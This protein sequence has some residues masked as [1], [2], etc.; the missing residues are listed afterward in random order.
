MGGRVGVL[1]VADLAGDEA[2]VHDHRGL[3]VEA[4]RHGLHE[5]PGPLAL[6]ALAVHL[7]TG[8]HDA[9]TSPKRRLR[10]RNTVHTLTHLPS[11]SPNVVPRCRD[12]HHGGERV[13]AR[14]DLRGEH[15]LEQLLRQG[16]VAH[17]NTPGFV[18]ARMRA[19]TTDPSRDARPRW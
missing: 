9:S 5:L 6:P 10:K 1:L 4:V 3:E 15:V 8:I 2:G 17:L 14:A 16:Q 7:L 19:R 11:V 12:L 13:H 18:H